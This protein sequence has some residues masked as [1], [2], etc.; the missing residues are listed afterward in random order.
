MPSV[1]DQFD[2]FALCKAAGT[3]NASGTVVT[4]LVT[5]ITNLQKIAW[6]VSRIEYS[7][8][9][10]WLT[11]AIF[12]LADDYLVAGVTQ[13]SSTSQGVSPDNPAMVDWQGLGANHVVTA[14][15][16]QPI[17]PMPLIHDFPSRRL[18]LPQNI[19]AFIKWDLAAAITTAEVQIRIWYRER[20][21]T[22]QDWYDLLQLRLPLGAS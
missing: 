17:L 11:A 5:G 2:Q 14:V 16:I 19:F 21:L 20:E 9:Y 18:L 4:Q 8:P 3:A 1:L 22:A 13:S 15:G 7:I 6:E 12:G 10:A